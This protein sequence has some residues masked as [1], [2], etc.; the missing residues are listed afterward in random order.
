MNTKDLRCFQMV[1]EERSISRAA[2]R[3]FITP[4]GLSKNI[5]LLETELGTTLFERTAQGMQPTES[6]CFL[7]EKSE[8]II[9]EFGEVENGIRQ[10]ELRR[11]RIRVGCANGVLNLLPLAQILE[12]GR[13]YPQWRL[14]WREYPNQEVKELLLGSCIDYGF[15]IGRWNDERVQTQR[16]TGCGICLL[17]WEGHSLWNRESV[18]FEDLRGEK[19]LVMNESFQIYHDFMAMCAVRG[20][21]PHVEAK[22]ADGAGLYHLC[23][24][25]MGLAVAPEFF[26][27]EFNM[28]GVRA[29]PFQENMRWEVL[30]V[31]KRE[32]E[33]Y[34][35]V[36]LFEQYVREHVPEK[37]RI[38][39]HQ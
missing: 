31:C 15:I 11:K 27:D 8:K 6:A 38:A 12:F 20:V 3:L 39:G 26:Q 13:R 5:R 2:K 35:N 32:A 14:E 25:K 10:M 33:K 28:K 7:Y 4:Q 30:G 18:D 9:R 22:T 16:V 23:R 24:Q 1:Y 19:L 36:R 37:K 21:V 29:L 34:E 17:V